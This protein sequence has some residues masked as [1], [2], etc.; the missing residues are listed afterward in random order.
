MGAGEGNR[1]D[2]RPLPVD[3]ELVVC[4]VLAAIGIAQDRAPTV[5]WGLKGLRRTVGP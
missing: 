5:R 4:A 2:E 1:R 3:V